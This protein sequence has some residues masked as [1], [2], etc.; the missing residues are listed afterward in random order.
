MTFEEKKSSSPSSI[1]ESSERKQG[2][3]ASGLPSRL[4]I[5]VADDLVYNRQV[6]ANIFRRFDWH[7]TEV[8]SAEEV[9]ERML[10]AGEHYDILSIDEHFGVN[11]L[12]GSEAIR[13]LRSKL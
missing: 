8:E 12:L 1:E 7:V 11:R 13:Q 6:M 4:R 2:L 5:L 10:Q 9:L 3:A